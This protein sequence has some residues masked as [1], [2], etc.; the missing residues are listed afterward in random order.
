MSSSL[1]VIFSESSFIK[2]IFSLLGKLWLF[3]GGTGAGTHLGEYDVMSLL[4]GLS[5]SKI[6]S[7]K[8]DLEFRL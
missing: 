5:F 1:K 4:V 2:I 6:L 8:I 7:N 3:R